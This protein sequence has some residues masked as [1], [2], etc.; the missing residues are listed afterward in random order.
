[1]DEFIEP[2]THSSTYI[3]VKIE[4]LEKITNEF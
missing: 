2:G 4:T 1:M 3:K